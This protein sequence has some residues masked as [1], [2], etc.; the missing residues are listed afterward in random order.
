MI[1]A[2]TFRTN[3]LI[4]RC[5]ICKSCIL[6]KKEREKERQTFIKVSQC[7]AVVSVLNKYMARLKFF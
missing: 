4:L 6:R 3:I 1:L 7:L 5:H 2:I